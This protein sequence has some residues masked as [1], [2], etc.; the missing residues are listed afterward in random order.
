MTPLILCVYPLLTP[1]IVLLVA[2][3]L[4][5]PE[6]CVMSQVPVTS[7]E[8]CMAHDR[9]AVLRRVREQGLAAWA[10]CGR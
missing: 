3:G 6:P 5:Q 2:M 7:Y 10:E 9:P 8:H 4:A 1:H